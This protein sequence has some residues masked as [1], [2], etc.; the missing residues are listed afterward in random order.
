VCVV[1]LA[2]R[3]ELGV[4][5]GFLGRLDSSSVGQGLLYG[6]PQRISMILC[7]FKAFIVNG[8]K[9]MSKTVPHFSEWA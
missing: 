7:G 6:S 3:G 1:Y 4:Q 9:W 5:G 8:G 2:W